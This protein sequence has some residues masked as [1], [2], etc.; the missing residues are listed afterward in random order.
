MMHMMV[1][2]IRRKPMH[3]R[4]H[5]HKTG[6]RQRSIGIGPIMIFPEGSL[7]KIVL[8]IEQIGSQSGHDEDGHE[9]GKK[10]YLESGCI[11]DQRTYEDMDQERKKRVEVLSRAFHER[12]QVEPVDEQS[13]IAEDDGERMP[14]DK[15][16]GSLR[17]VQGQK[18]GLTHGRK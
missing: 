15:V 7:R 2:D 18:P 16:N 13:K 10:I 12:L 8:A 5:F 6:R 4:A 1:A 17:L 9:P 14:V 3:H 11:P